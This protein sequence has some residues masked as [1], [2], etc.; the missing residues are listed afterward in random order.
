[1]LGRSSELDDALADAR[2]PG[3]TEPVAV[4]SS[5]PD[6]M[7]RRCVAMLEGRYADGERSRA[8]RSRS[9]AGSQDRTGR[10]AIGVVLFPLL[11]EQGR[12]ARARRVRPAGRSRSS[13]GSRRG[14]PGS[15]R[16]S[17]TR[18]SS[19]KRRSTSKRSRATTSPSSPTTC[20]RTYTL[21]R[22]GRGRSSA[23]RRD[24]GERLYELL[25]PTTPDRA[26]CSASSAYHGAVDRYLGLL[27]T[28]LGR[29][30]DAVAHH[31]AA[32]VHPRAHARRPVGRA[33]AVRPRGCARRS[34][35]AS[36]TASARS[37]C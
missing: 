9:R 37:A 17:P 5:T 7:P 35:R 2:A 23:P 13:R 8:K 18:A 24:L 20:S 34:W 6:A 22:A 19:T 3:R 14:A 15:R 27:A 4:L 1:M 10:R 12:S 16:C 36:S 32:L 31:E 29:H 30:D 26:R 28:T 33:F 21:C 25:A 11:R